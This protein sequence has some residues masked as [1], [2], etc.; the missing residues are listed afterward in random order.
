MG[1]GASSGSSRARRGEFLAG[2]YGAVDELRPLGGGFWSSAY[3]FSHAGRALVVRFG[4][5]KD[6][7]R[8]RQGGH[9]VRLTGPPVPEVVE[10]GDVFGGAYAVS[11]RHYGTNLEERPA[12][13]VRCRRPDA[14]VAA[15][16]ALP[17][18]EEP[19]PACRLALAATSGDLDLAELALRAPRGRPEPGRSRLAGSPYRSERGR[20]GSS[21]PVRHASATSSKPAPSGVTWSTGTSSMP[22]S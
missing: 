15:R 12:R 7:F 16:G 13:P 4:A 3:S 2:K 11:A 22:T 17:G 8:S 19:G 5:N 1:R 9:G 6:W 18:A 20:P 10:I 14:G 21:G